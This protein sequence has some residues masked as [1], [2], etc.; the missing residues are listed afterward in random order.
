VRAW[1]WARARS[2]QDGAS[3]LWGRAVKGP[4]RATCS[5]DAAFA[6]FPA[7]VQALCTTISESIA[8]PD[9]DASDEDMPSGKGVQAQVH[10]RLLSS[11]PGRAFWLESAPDSPG[12]GCDRASDS[13]VTA[14]WESSRVLLEDGWAGGTSISSNADRAHSEWDRANRGGNSA[15]RAR[16]VCA[17]PGTC[18]LSRDALQRQVRPR[19]LP[20]TAR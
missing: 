18:R 7:A 14:S 9:G 19:C 12:I 4:G 3:F 11:D 13:S 1:G 15:D 10:L 17:A 16:E 20:P 2:L 8:D 5:A 6:P